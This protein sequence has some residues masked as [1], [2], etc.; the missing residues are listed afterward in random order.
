MIQ[1]AVFSWRTGLLRT[2]ATEPIGDRA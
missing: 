2:I 1:F